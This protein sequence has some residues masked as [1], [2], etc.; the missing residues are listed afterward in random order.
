MPH[1][2]GGLY[3]VI[4][5]CSIALIM[6]GF[7]GA[8]ELL[9]LKY[10]QRGEKQFRQHEYSGA[11][12]NFLR[13]ERLWMLNTSKQTFTSRANDCRR[14]ARIVEMMGEAAS[15]C[16]IT[17]DTNGYQSV[18]KEM[19]QFLLNQSPAAAAQWPNLYSRFRAARKRF[20]AETRTLKA[21]TLPGNLA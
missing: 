13:A 3:I 15:N 2:P 17:V 21:N 20:H 6:I 12:N 11:I 10:S 16:S 19:E 9:F 5:I 4:G 1:L 18:L 8:R 7:F 14:L